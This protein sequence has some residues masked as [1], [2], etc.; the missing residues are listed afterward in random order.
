MHFNI[1]AHTKYNSVKNL[2]L[3]IAFILFL[4]LTSCESDSDEEVIN[5]SS[6][7]PNVTIISNDQDNM[8]VFQVD[9]TD[10]GENVFTSNLTDEIG[11][12][13]T[14]SNV[15]YENEIISFFDRGFP[16]FIYTVY[17]KQVSTGETNI[18][19]D[20]CTPTMVNL[21]SVKRSDQKI[22]LFTTGSS[23]SNLYIQDKDTDGCT[24]INFSNE[25][26]TYFGTSRVDNEII[27]LYHYDE[28]NQ[29]KIVSID[30]RTGNI[31]NELALDPLAR[32]SIIDNF[33]YAQYS[34]GQL[35]IY[36]KNSF[37]LLNELQIENVELTFEWISKIENNSD[38]IVI[39]IPLPAPGFSA[40]SPAIYNI[41][42]FEIEKGGSQLY[43]D[44]RNNLIDEVEIGSG[45]VI[46]DTDVQ[47]EII[48][49]SYRDLSG[50]HNLLFSNFDAEI[51]KTVPLDRE[52]TEIFIH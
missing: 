2:I 7:I 29:L 28:S 38:K 33:L 15:S 25:F 49:L 22:I 20:V 50:N 6:S 1:L 48:V 41:S 4:F 21:I 19:E 52:P 5:G 27:Y 36:D 51:L 23:G 13:V 10:D 18:Y 17:E 46:Y 42:T 9:I 40:I 34:G 37:E 30:L 31:L 12:P 26:L 16:E 44:I 11:L 3:P 24:T 14:Y 32:V 43:S 35:Q 45:P 39:N 47:S 8:N